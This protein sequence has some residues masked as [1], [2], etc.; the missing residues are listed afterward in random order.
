MPVP[1]NKSNVIPPT[2]DTVVYVTANVF[3]CQITK[4]IPIGN[5]EYYS[6][7]STISKLS[8]QL[9]EISNKVSPHALN[10]PYSV[11]SISSYDDTTGEWYPFLGGKVKEYQ[12][13]SAQSD[14]VWHS[15]FP[16]YTVEIPSPIDNCCYSDWILA[17]YLFFLISKDSIGMLVTDIQMSFSKLGVSFTDILKDVH[18]SKSLSFLEWQQL[19]TNS[20]YQ[21]SADIRHGLSR[22]SSITSNKRLCAA[23]KLPN[24]YLS[25]SICNNV[26]KELVCRKSDY[27]ISKRESSV[28]DKLENE[29]KKLKSRREGGVSPITNINQIDDQLALAV[30]KVRAQRETSDFSDSRSTHHSQSTESSRTVDDQ[31]ERAVQKVRRQRETGIFSD[32]LPLE[33]SAPVKSTSPETVD[34]KLALAVQRVRLQR[35]TGTLS[36]SAVIK[37]EEVIIKSSKDETIDDKLAL[38]VKKMRCQ[39]ETGTIVESEWNVKS[40]DDVGRVAVSSSELLIKSNDES[41]DEKLARAVQRMRFQRENN[42]INESRQT[43]KSV[44]PTE[45]ISSSQ[46]ELV[47]SRRSSTA[48]TSDDITS[49]DNILLKLKETKP[50][51]QVSTNDIDN[52]IESKLT[53]VRNRRESGPSEHFTKKDRAIDS[54]SI[55]NDNHVDDE[56]ARKLKEVRARREG[57]NSVSSS[58]PLESTEITNPTDN[59]LTIKLNKVRSRR[60]S[61][62]SSLEVVQHTQEDE[63]IAD[64]FIDLPNTQISLSTT[65]TITGTGSE[66]SSKT[67]HILQEHLQRVKLQ[68]ASDAAVLS[69]DSNNLRNEKQI[70][71]VVLNPI[72]EEMATKRHAAGEHTKQLQLLTTNVTKVSDT[73]QN[74]VTD[75]IASTA[76]EVQL[77]TNTKPN[78]NSTNWSHEIDSLEAAVEKARA[79]RLALTAQ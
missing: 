65:T 3:G 68:R 62:T 45:L 19:F 14:S 57:S 38:A 72:P 59:N 34:D 22:D 2:R 13:L 48:T 58:L 24:S 43:A 49:V 18:W 42:I 32:S 66:F 29:L 60:L 79:R 40:A 76:S 51:R 20:D 39:R 21:L 56:M 35:E 7:S 71:S 44:S 37:K 52:E 25:T 41:V 12:L 64:E 69:S 55:R 70:S 53:E 77:T 36:E 47:K 15:N 23:L 17:R 27:L 54:K 10:E 33:I 50:Q 16:I 9:T 46:T 1:I 31:L 5:D 74:S 4:L 67:Q 73:T 75:L 78:E 61:G 28:E 6:E 63:S 11:N 26:D 30:K 8:T